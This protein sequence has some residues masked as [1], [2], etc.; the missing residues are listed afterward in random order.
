MIIY[1]VMLHLS[2]WTNPQSSKTV[3]DLNKQIKRALQIQTAFYSQNT[4]LALF[5][6]CSSHLLVNALILC[7]V[8]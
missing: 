8:A 1:S 5:E 2:T 4:V 3:R 6:V 7:S